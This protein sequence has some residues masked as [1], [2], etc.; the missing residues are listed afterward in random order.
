MTKSNTVPLNQIRT[1]LA[2]DESATELEQHLDQ[3]DSVT[4]LHAVFQL[5]PD[6][7][8]KLLSAVSAR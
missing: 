1:W 7:Q 2:T 8:R 5:T 4:L 3:V 6:E